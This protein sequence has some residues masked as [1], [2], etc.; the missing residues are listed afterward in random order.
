ML[1]LFSWFGQILSPLQ[2]DDRL[3]LNDLEAADP[4]H[5]LTDAIDQK[6]IKLDEIVDRLDVLLDQLYHC[7]TG[8]LASASWLRTAQR[9]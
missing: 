8:T 5:L 4:C 1:R 7:R 3:R 9:I 6:T 2:Q